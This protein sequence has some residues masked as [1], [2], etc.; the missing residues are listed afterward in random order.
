MT[1]EDRA[2]AGETP[3]PSP[4]EAVYVAED[5]RGKALWMASMGLALRDSA[6]TPK[7]IPLYVDP[8][9]TGA[10]SAR[11]PGRRLRGSFGTRPCAFCVWAHAEIQARFFYEAMGGKL[12]AERTTSMMGVP[13]PEIALAGPSSRLPASRSN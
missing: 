12:I 13:V 9:M 4:R 2:H 10:G 8:M 1:V 7:S 6:T 11:A 3:S 5:D